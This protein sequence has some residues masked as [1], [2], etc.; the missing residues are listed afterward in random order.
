MTCSEFHAVEVPLIF[1]HQG[2]VIPEK[3]E[4]PLSKEEL[5]KKA[6]ELN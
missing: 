3:M 4:K 5:K 6:Q 2:P 1:L